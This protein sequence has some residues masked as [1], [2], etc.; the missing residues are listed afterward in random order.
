MKGRNMPE[1]SVT[2]RRAT[3]EDSAASGQICYDAFSTINREHGFPCDFPSVEAAK[4]MLAMAFAAP[5]F[6]CVVAE[7]NG[8]I[9]G[10]NCMD[11][12]STIHGIG[13]IT[14]ALAGQNGGVGR[15]LMEAV[16]QRAEE[17]GAAGMRLVQ[18]AFH[19]RSLSLY[20]RLGFDIREPLSCL[21]GRTAQR[22]VD[23]CAVRVATQDD[24]DRCNTLA[25]AL[26]GFDRSAEV[27]EAIGRGAASVVVR[28]GRITAYA[29]GL[30]FFCHAVA[31]TNA[32]LQA[33]IAS[34]E[35]FGGPG[36]LLPSRNAV[37][38]RWCLGNGLRIVQPMTLMSKGLYN[39]PEGAWLPSIFF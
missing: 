3:P 24:L 31:E 11:E 33:L 13:P 26:H 36:I 35:T 27:A 2:I 10:S 39:E 19:N 37:M 18:A 22:T 32:D 20:T 30:A 17:N 8:L 15:S 6:Y 14:V 1:E 23:G 28:D 7:R 5:G 21:Q 25:R 38:L 4:G 29:T 16:M 12:R 9:V 34:V